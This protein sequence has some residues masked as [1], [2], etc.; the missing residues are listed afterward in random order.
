MNILIFLQA[1][2]LTYWSDALLVIVAVVVLAV[3][4][5]RGKKDLVK[6][7]IYT[8]VVK[9]EKELGSATGSAKYSQVITTLYLKLPFILRLF[10]TKVEL[11]KY[12]EDAVSWLKIKLEDPKVTLLS[13]D[14]EAVIN[15]APP[16]T[17][18]V[19][20]STSQQ[21]AEKLAEE[22]AFYIKQKTLQLI[23][24]DK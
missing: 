13:Y 6:E 5:K 23:N 9:A 16:L 4:Y 21:N 20:N 15:N 11:N 8:L 14:Q 18:N 22:L 10:F 2:L 24:K 1:L 12:I 7:I 17:I 3:L 19:E